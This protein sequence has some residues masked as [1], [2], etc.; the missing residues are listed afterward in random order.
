MTCK[1]RK[2]ELEDCR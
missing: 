1:T 2:S